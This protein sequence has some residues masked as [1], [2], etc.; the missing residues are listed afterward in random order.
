MNYE[1]NRPATAN[2][3]CFVSSCDDGKL[4]ALGS[5]SDM[6]LAS[7]PNQSARAV[8]TPS[9]GEVGK[10]RWLRPMLVLELSRR[11]A[12]YSPKILPPLILPPSKK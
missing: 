9:H 3:C 12:G 8:Q 5:S 4:A 6:R 7:T 10:N 1:W 2:S 11:E